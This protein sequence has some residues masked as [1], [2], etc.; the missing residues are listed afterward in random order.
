MS[1]LEVD[2]KVRERIL[3][4]WSKERRQACDS[5]TIVTKR[6]GNIMNQRS[7]VLSFFYRCLM[8]TL[9][10]IP[11]F[12]L[13]YTRLV[14]TNH[15]RYQN[16]HG[17]FYL[18]HAG[19]GRKIPQ[20]WIGTAGQKPQLSDK[21]LL[22]DTARLVLLI[23]LRDD[24]ANDTVKVD[25]ILEAISMPKQI[26]TSQDVKYLVIGDCKKQLNMYNGQTFFP[27]KEDELLREGIEPV[28]GYNEKALER[29]FKATEKY[30]ILR[31]D[32]FIHSVADNLEGL[33]VNLAKVRAYFCDSV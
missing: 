27:C 12:G 29:T 24:Q 4:G 13:W 18:E 6:N 16:V 20:I 5:A 2:K 23:L 3:T 33:S 17:G 21:I 28:K 7:V 26:L 10:S 1:Q 11:G 14:F 31:P 8:S 19:G 32:C 9:Y 22:G 30:I 15:F 25:E